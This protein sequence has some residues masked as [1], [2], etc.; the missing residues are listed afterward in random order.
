MGNPEGNALAVDVDAISREL[1][2]RPE[3]LKRII[4][5]FSKTLTEKMFQLEGALADD[6]AVFMRAL[7]H[8]IRGTSGNLRLAVVYETAKTLHEAVKAGEEK[9]RLQE[10]FDALK[11]CSSQLTEYAKNEE[12]KNVENTN[13]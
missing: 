13:R 8:E 1:R 4:I 5:S 2:V 12:S 7:L 11:V 10:Y 9:K 6:N 3:I